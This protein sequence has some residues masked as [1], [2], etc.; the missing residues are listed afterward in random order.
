[1]HRTID[2]VL[3]KKNEAYVEYLLFMAH[4]LECVLTTHFAAWEESFGAR[5]QTLPGQRLYLRGNRQ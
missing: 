4:A 3:S 5:N 1:M 2:L